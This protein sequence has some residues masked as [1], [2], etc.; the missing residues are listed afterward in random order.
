MFGGLVLSGS[1]EVLCGTGEL[2]FFAGAAAG[3]TEP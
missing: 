1:G 2:F 3:V